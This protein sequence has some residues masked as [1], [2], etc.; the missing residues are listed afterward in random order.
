[1][2]QLKCGFAQVD[3]T[4]N[5]PE[6]VFLD[7]YGHRNLPAQGVRD[8]LYGKVMVVSGVQDFYLVSLDICGLSGGLKDHL[9]R[10]ITLLTGIKRE[11]FALCAT[12]THAGPAC[13]VLNPFPLNWLY[14]NKV[15]E[16]VADAM[17]A[18]GKNACEGCFRFA[19]KDGFA[20]PFNRRGKQDINRNIWVV[21][22]YDEADRLK[23]VVTS[24][25][26]HAVCN[27]E[28]T[29]SADFPGVLT[30]R[31]AQQYPDVPFLYLQNR[32][33]DINP[34]CGGEEGIELVGNQLTD[35]VFD[36]L[37]D[38]QKA[39]A[40]TGSV[41]SGFTTIQLPLQYPDKEEIVE[42]IDEFRTQLL[43]V[44]EDDGARRYPE[45]EL[46]WYAKALEQVEKHGR[47]T[48]LPVDLQVLCL[49]GQA[50]FAFA[51]F[52]LLTATGNAIEQAMCDLGIKSEQ[53]IV[54]GYANGTHSYL[55]PAAEYGQY[56]YE[57]RLASHWYDIPECTEKTEPV[58]IETLAG[59]AKSLL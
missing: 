24:A 56:G 32:G 43:D 31:G 55:C 57:T 23:G 11:H 41:A 3:I 46:I 28:Y 12:H 40:V 9:C 42:K 37:A 36:L 4:P 49:G 59:L 6:E 30:A 7:G 19:K 25:S 16:K 2:S 20:A 54:V 47:E 29:I 17:L 35:M 26:C 52:E 13:G 27:T 8:P 50:V 58:V 39:P 22:F 53:C 44:K 21:G 51:P 34:P 1:M 45:T 33:A 14:W 48:T 38:L 18:A 10:I 15:A 5:V